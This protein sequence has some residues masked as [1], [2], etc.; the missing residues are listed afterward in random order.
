MP[1]KISA[2]II[3]LLTLSTIIIPTNKISAQ[4]SEKDLTTYVSKDQIAVLEFDTTDESQNK[5]IKQFV[6]LFIQNMG[7]TTEKEQKIV[8]H[9]QKLLTTPNKLL[10]TGNLENIDKIDFSNENDV[11]DNL[12]INILFY[13]KDDYLNSII[14]L[15]PTDQFTITQKNDI[16][17]VTDEDEM[18]SMYISKI[19]E[20]IIISSQKSEIEKAITLKVED[21]LFSNPELKISKEKIE[22]NLK[23]K[24][25]FFGYANF[26]NEELKKKIELN[27]II[28]SQ[29][30]SLFLIDSISLGMKIL[31]NGL[32]STSLMVGNQNYIDNKYIPF[33]TFKYDVGFY[34]QFPNEDVYYFTE[35]FN[36]KE[37]IKLTVKGFTQQSLNIPTWGDEENEKINPPTEE[38][39]NKKIQESYL[40][41]ETET[42][43]NI[44]KDIYSWM[45]KEL[46]VSMQNSNTVIPSINILIN[47]ASNPEG[48]K[49]VIGKINESIT[50][51]IKSLIDLSGGAYITYAERKNGTGIYYEMKIDLLEMLAGR[52][53]KINNY[54]T[55]LEGF[56]QPLI[57][58]FGITEDNI[59]FISTTPKITEKIGEGLQKNEDFASILKQIE[60]GNAGMVYVSIKNI[61][62]YMD[63]INNLYVTMNAR[64]VDAKNLKIYYSILDLCDKVK[65]MISTGYAEKYTQSNTTFIQTNTE[66]Q[67]QSRFAKLLSNLEKQDSDSDGRSDFEEIF[68]NRTDPYTKGE[69]KKNAFE[70]INSKEWYS[71][72]VYSLNNQGII[73]GYEDNKNNKTTFKPDQPITRAE[74]IKLTI[75]AF[76]FPTSY[77]DVPYSDIQY[78]EWYFQYVSSATQ[79]GLVNGYQD[80]TFRPFNPIT[81]A[82]ALKII[83]SAQKIKIPNSEKNIF[84]DTEGHW[85]Q[86]YINYA[87]ENN[88]VKGVNEKTFEPNR[89]INRA[90]AAKLIIEAQ[91]YYL[92]NLKNETLGKVIDS[93]VAEIPVIDNFID[94]NTEEISIIEE[95]KPANIGAFAQ[96]LTDKGFVLYGN[97]TCSFCTD[98]KNLFK[99]SV[100]KLKIVECPEDRK[101]CT[102]AGITAFPTWMSK[103]AKK[104]LGYRD[105][106]ALSEMSGCALN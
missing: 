96:C 6:D 20:I 94:E 46:G 70:D 14:N 37:I 18:D 85:A 80:N 19:N 41:F 30:Q 62:Q 82:E 24:S 90:E 21:S 48:A 47:A 104:H 75:K 101:K 16:T 22:K 78:G 105:F 66:T 8:D 87:Y 56:I 34:K 73:S 25:L 3:S 43:L 7:A 100:N 69:I 71:P 12:Y 98:Q 99:D 40:Q 65:D 33:D 5:F 61:L 83:L 38:E 13:D 81:R 39:I 97:D 92:Q 50:A 53:E 63:K 44:E 74:F 49:K 2:I 79:F 95:I 59:F 91:S 29:L 55:L 52:D 36:L 103:E 9:F 106:A 1:K 23:G 54:K 93:K 64:K 76:D 77:E 58:S 42:G 89:P 26:N 32:L 86:K 28:A 51:N 11:I 102:Q 27:P 45:D 10:F 4:S 60:L 31:D 72:Y 57:I 67:N 88:L 35:N 15:F 17:T 84:T 68:I